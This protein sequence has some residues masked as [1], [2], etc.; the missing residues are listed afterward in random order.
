MFRG[1]TKRGC[2]DACLITS[3]PLYF[4]QADSPW[5]TNKPATVYFEVKI[6]SLGRHRQQDENSIAIGFCAVPYPTWRMP[7]WERGS[8]AI[9]SD[10]GNRYVSDN[11]GGKDFTS[12]FK[13]GETIG[14]GI[15]FTHPGFGQSST[16]GIDSERSLNGEVFFTRG[17]R[18]AGS[19]DLHEEVDSEHDR[20]THGLDGGYDLYGSVGVYGAVAFEMILD[21][22]KWLWRPS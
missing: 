14:L 6:A 17:G 4:A 5:V 16:S 15:N 20:G 8:L 19:W 3:V 18:R 11:E 10:D 22:R 7:G 12:P 9:H 1:N 21:P 13:D 2:R